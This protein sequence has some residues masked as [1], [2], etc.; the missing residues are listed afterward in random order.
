MKMKAND[1]QLIVCIHHI[2]TFKRFERKSAPFL[3]GCMRYVCC[4]SWKYIKTVFIFTNHTVCMYGGNFSQISN[5]QSF[6]PDELKI[7][8]FLIST[9][10]GRLFCG[11]SKFAH[12][13][14]DLFVYMCHNAVTAALLYIT[15]K[16][17]G[18]YLCR[19]SWFQM[20]LHIQS[21]NVFMI[22]LITDFSV[23]HKYHA[24][25]CLMK[26][27]LFF[28]FSFHTIDKRHNRCIHQ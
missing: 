21:H 24:Y 17:N 20:P 14:S 1:T 28:L 25:V 16:K 27:L 23:T 26:W 10:S 18:L 12:N 6:S 4:F 13:A 15:T 5:F 8:R 9:M 19:P 3:Y 2:S 22:P 7:N 11:F